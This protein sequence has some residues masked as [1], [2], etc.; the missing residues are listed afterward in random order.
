MC[1][2]IIEKSTK[3]EPVEESDYKSYQEILVEEHPGR[4]RLEKQ[5]EIFII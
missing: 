2:W 4:E 5:P 3:K 1:T